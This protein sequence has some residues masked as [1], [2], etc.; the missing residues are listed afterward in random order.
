MS[1]LADANEQ[2]KDFNEIG[3]CVSLVIAVVKFLNHFKA[4]KGKS[5]CPWLKEACFSKS[6][7][8]TPLYGISSP[9]MN[10]LTAHSVKDLDRI[11]AKNKFYLVVHSVDFWKDIS[12]FHPF[13]KKL[14]VISIDAINIWTICKIEQILFFHPWNILF[15]T[16]IASLYNVLLAFNDLENAQKW[17]K[18]KLLLV[19]T[20]I[21]NISDRIDLISKC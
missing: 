7:R 19:A 17:P 6:A 11:S 2:G 14:S 12:T 9:L 16:Q 18:S 13:F 20:P 5:K 1:C 8:S 15:N 10:Y 21:T 3:P 4:S